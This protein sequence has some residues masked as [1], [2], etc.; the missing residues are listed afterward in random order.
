MEIKIKIK[1]GDYELS[2]SPE[3][4]KGLYDTLEKIFGE[5]IERIDPVPYP[6]TPYIYHP[7][8]IVPPTKWISEDFGVKNNAVSQS[9]YDRL[10]PTSHTDARYD[11]ERYMTLFANADPMLQHHSA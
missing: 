5:R 11:A 2:L 6:P 8:T 4:A 10:C 9:L 3:E 1:I 7:E